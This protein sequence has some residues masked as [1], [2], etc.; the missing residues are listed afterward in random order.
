MPL[1]ALHQL[2]R[3]LDALPRGDR[4]AILAALTGRERE[5]IRKIDRTPAQGP[6]SPTAVHSAWLDGLLTEGRP[7]ITTAARAALQ[8][9][10]SAQPTSAE[11]ARGRS[12]MQAAGGLLPRSL[13]R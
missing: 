10:A 1:E 5:R 6:M 13:S 11:P 12:L 9:A 4:S 8:A 3:E 7:D 2:V